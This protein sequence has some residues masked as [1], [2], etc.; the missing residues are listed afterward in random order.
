MS[1]KV[2]FLLWIDCA[3]SLSIFKIL[4][5][6]CVQN[7]H[8]YELLMGLEKISFFISKRGLKRG[9][10][11]TFY[12]F[13]KYGE[14]SPFIQFCVFFHWLQSFVNGF[15]LSFTVSEINSIERGQQFFFIKSL[16]QS[17]E[18]YSLYP[19]LLL[20]IIIIIII[21]LSFKG[22]LWL[23]GSWIYNYLCNQCLSPLKLLV[24]ITIMARC[25]RYNNMW[26]NLSVTCG[27][28]AV[29]SWYIGFLHQLRV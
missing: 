22:L 28:L 27:R 13:G 26:K 9:Q 18:T 6:F 21:I 7:G 15:P 1:L 10:I 19:F 8:L 11:L 24:L 16:T 2:F 29:Y 17:L 25:F 12:I 5:I 4:C 14:F 23:Y 3:E 20:L